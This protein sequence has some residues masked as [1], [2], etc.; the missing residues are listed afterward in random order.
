MAISRVLGRRESLSHAE[1]VLWRALSSLSPRGKAWGKHSGVI[2]T[3]H[4]KPNLLK[5][6]TGCTAERLIIYKS[7]LKVGKGVCQIS[8]MVK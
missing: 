2:F 7:H 6:L 1:C 4:S 5:R 3:S 8:D